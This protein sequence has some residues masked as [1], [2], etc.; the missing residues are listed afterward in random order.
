MRAKKYVV[1][2]AVAIFLIIFLITF[3]SVCAITQFDVEYNVGSAQMT[4]AAQRVQSTLEN[5]YL[6]K[7]YLFFKDSDIRDVVADEGG[8]Y[9]EITDISR[10]FPNKISVTVREKFENYAFVA[11][12]QDADGNPVYTYYAVGDD[13]T[14]LSVSIG[15]NKNSISGRNIEIAGFEFPEVQV[16][17]TFAVSAG[18]EDAYSALQTCFSVISSNDLRGNILRIEYDGFFDLP[19]P[20][21]WLAQFIIDCKEGVQIVIPDPQIRTQE[22]AEEA[23]RA[24]VNLGSEYGD[25]G[26]MEGRILVGT[27]S[28]TGKITAVYSPSE[29]PASDADA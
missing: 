10:T 12:G 19:D 2:Y 17:E 3:N 18:F 25:I 1:I 16:G 22:K 29:S 23:F 8:G 26:R 15:E 4:Q 20:A 6:N 5:R 21:D 7:S 27:E 24:Y 28:E 9:L 11:E 14:V 13:G